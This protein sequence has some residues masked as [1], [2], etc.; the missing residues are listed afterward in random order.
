[1]KEPMMETILTNAR[2]VCPDRE[3]NGSLIIADG[4]ISEIL[5][6]KLA[7]GTNLQGAILVPGII[8]IH[9]DYLER[10]ISPRPTAKIPLDLALHVMDLRAL[11]CG[12][13]TV[14]S[15]ARISEEREG[16]AGSWR[17]DGLG[18]AK[19]FQDL[20]PELRARHLIH[21][22]WSTNF[23]PVEEILD[24][25]LDLKS[26]ANLVF[27]D[28]TPGQRQFRDI[29]A[30]VQQRANRQNISLDDA[31]KQMEERLERTSKINNRMIVKARL[32]SRIPLGSHDDTTV[33]HVIE[34]FDSGATLSE[35]PCT[36]EAARMA[37]KLGMM[38]CMGAPNYYRGGSHCGNLAC[39]DAIA[40]NLVDIVCSDYHFPSMLACALRMVEEGMSLPEAVKLFTL[41]P[42]LHLGIGGR[43]G[44]IEVGKQADLV[45]FFPRNGYGDVARVWVGGEERF[46]SLIGQQGVERQQ[47][48]EAVAGLATT[49]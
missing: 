37:K 17:G 29:E 28:D 19:R 30:L 21:I 49:N 18:L 33:E 11:S 44:S 9:T 25:L 23:E 47:P 42:A 32:A 43:T 12:L 16:H 45:A 39:H 6:H 13:T 4:C 36:I 14:C 26:I 35:M 46:S 5:P 41:N 7:R 10:E 48:A 2:I 38:V 1:M 8:D 20:I 24:Q 27:N 34:A 22:R 15:A 31:R 3:I 40:E